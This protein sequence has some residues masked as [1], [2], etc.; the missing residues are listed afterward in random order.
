MRKLAI[1]VLALIMTSCTM[2]SSN[3]GNLD[4]MWHIT[5]MQNIETGETTDYS[6]KAYFW[7]VDTK[8]M[9]M[10]GYL[11]RFKQE[12]G[13]L[14]TYDVYY[15]NREGGDPVLTDTTRLYPYGMTSIPDTFQ[16][17]K[18][19]HYDMILKSKKRRITFEK[20]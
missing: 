5:E 19:K 3:N 16:I 14:I 20:Y 15:D 8:L 13:Y 6:E 18:M 1:G 7:K 9:Q 4:G 12:N 11:M 2:E 10:G 17:E